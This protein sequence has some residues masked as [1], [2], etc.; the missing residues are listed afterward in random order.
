MALEHEYKF[1]VKDPSC[2]AGVEGERIVQG[3]A[4]LERGVLRIRLRGDRAWLA[5][6]DKAGPMSSHEH[7]Y[8]IPSPDARDLLDRVCRDGRIEKTRYNIPFAGRTWEVDVFEG[9]LRG[10]VMAELEVEHPGAA[11][12]RPPWLGRDVTGQLAYSNFELARHPGAVLP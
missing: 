11:F 9:A 10:L 5:I 12:E 3:Y 4:R 6:K 7:E 8:P 1:L 2:V